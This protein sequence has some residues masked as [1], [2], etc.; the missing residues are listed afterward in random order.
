MSAAGAADELARTRRAYGRF[1]AQIFLLDWFAHHSTK[2]DRHYARFLRQ[3]G[4]PEA[5]ARNP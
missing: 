5:M 3:C 2:I 1:R 4:A